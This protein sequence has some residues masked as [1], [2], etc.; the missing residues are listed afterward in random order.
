M[1]T[2]E[3][4]LDFYRPENFP[5]NHVLGIFEKVGGHYES[6]YNALYCAYKCLD[7][8]ETKKE[9]EE[10]ISINSNVIFDICGNAKSK[11]AKD[12]RFA[13]VAGDRKEVDKLL[14]FYGIIEEM[15]RHVD[16]AFKNFKKEEEEIW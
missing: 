3:S 11:I 12:L 9:F 1:Q 8:I 7:K 15:Q 14:Y 6:A 5:Y 10:L 13:G 4:F 2:P 16:V